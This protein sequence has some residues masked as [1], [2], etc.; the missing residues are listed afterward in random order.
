[1]AY[2]EYR[3]ATSQT[4]L[5]FQGQWQDS[6]QPVAGAGV[7]LEA[8]PSPARFLIEIDGQVW[9]YG[10]QGD[11]LP[12][13]SRI[14]VTG[15]RLQVDTLRVQRTPYDELLR[16][17][18]EGALASGL[19]GSEVPYTPGLRE[20]L[21]RSRHQSVRCEEQALAL[22][23]APRARLVQ[24]H[25][26]R[27]VDPEQLAQL[28]TAVQQ[29]ELDFLSLQLQRPPVHYLTVQAAAT[30][31]RARQRELANLQD[32]TVRFSGVLYLRQM[33]RAAGPTAT[34]VTP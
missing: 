31:R 23:F 2:R 4:V 22:A 28:E 7:I 27:K 21:P 18:P 8:S 10:E 16:L 14:R 13:Q 25:P 1:M 24:F 9:V 3:D 17:V 19:L 32:T 15:R 34:G 12:R 5:E 33:V 30:R 26:S 20:E 6:R 11:I 29:Q